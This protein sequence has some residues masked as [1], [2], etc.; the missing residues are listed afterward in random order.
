MQNFKNVIC[1]VSLLTLCV[2]LVSGCGGGD[3]PPTVY[4]VSGKVT[5][6]DK[7]LANARLTFMPA[8]EGGKGGGYATTKE[9]GTYEL[10]D[11]QQA[12]C[13]PGQYKVVV[14]RYLT[15]DGKPFEEKP[16]EGLDLGQAIEAGDVKESL[17]K[18]YSNPE[19]TEL[20]ATIKEEDN[21]SVNFKL[22]SK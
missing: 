11:G 14:S 4:A 16:E 3:E 2:T 21:E 15:A 18:R 9:D 7:P 20:T 22:T 6:D 8:T 19:Q 17:P 12:G 13:M 10:T 1:S 5:L